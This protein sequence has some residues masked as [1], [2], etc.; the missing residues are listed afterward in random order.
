MQ[1]K[2]IKL[3]AVVISLMILTLFVFGCGKQGS[4]FE[5][6]APTISITSYEGFNPDNP[7]TDSTEVTLFQ[8]RIFWHASDPDGVIAGYAYRILADTDGNPDTPDVPISTAGNLFIDSQGENTPSDVLNT[9]G[10]G[11]VLHYKEGANQT[12]PL[13][14]PDAQKTIWTNNKYATVNFIAANAEGDSITTI[15]K[16]EVICVDNRGAICQQMAYRVFRSY[17]RIPTCLLSTTRGNPGGQ[18][19]GTGLKLSFALTDFDPFI[20]PTPWYYKFKVQKWTAVEV[21]DELVPG[22]FVSEIPSD[23]WVSTLNQPRINQFQLT[24]YTYPALSSDFDAAG[25]Q[26][27]FTRV[28]ARVIDLAGIESEADTIFFAVKEGFRPRT[29][30]YNKRVLAIGAN[31]Y[32]DYSDT[33]TPEVLP[34][35]IINDKQLFATPFFRD[36]EGYYTAVKSSN[37]KCWIRWGWHGEYGVQL[38]S[39]SVQ[40]TDDPYTKK[41]DLLLDDQTNVNYFSEITGFDIRLDNNP[42]N[43]PPLANSIHVDNDGKR[44]LRVPVNSSLGQTIVLTGL[45]ANTAAFPFHLFEVRAVDLQDEVGTVAEFR[46][47]IV[48]PVSRDSKA[49][50]LVIDDEPNNT[51]FAPEDSI[52]A[53]YANMLS[54]FGGLVDFRKRTGID[55]TLDT[56]IRFRKFALSDIQKYKLIIYHSDW[57]TNTANFPIDHDAFALYLNQGGNMIVSGGGNLHSVVQAVELATQ[58]TFETYFGITYRLDATAST[59]T[60]MIQKTWFVQGKKQTSNFHDLDLAFDLNPTVATSQPFYNN[61]ELICPDPNEMFHTILLNNR[62]GLGPITLFNYYQSSYGA[63]VTP[64]FKYGSK[65]V[66]VQPSNANP[67]YYCPQTEADF[68]SVNNKVIAL[69]KVIPNH[70]TCYI[71]GVPL[72]YMTRASSKQLLNDIMAELGM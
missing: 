35:T 17:S 45:E 34:T 38:A 32:I 72:S 19:V 48:D 12:V 59:S 14:D 62:K 30:V 26:T 40:V 43:Y 44:W 50:V 42:Y 11:W 56:D 27:T 64:L 53:K 36:T 10:T 39:G 4:R 37:L 63:S 68:S 66:Y 51:N 47:K 28:I 6:I 70:S 16:F 61:G 21:N 58:Q 1:I 46:F 22:E 60:S 55:Y 15:S 65:P 52:D 57:P 24:K 23:S 33:S 29:L 67:N 20:Q 71:F 5:N 18:L 54:D 31:H 9:F 8:Q 25:N 3:F 69:R 7:Y 13:D 49:G 2:S 41:V